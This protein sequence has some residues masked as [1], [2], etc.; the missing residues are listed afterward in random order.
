MKKML[1]GLMLM[2]VSAVVSAATISISEFPKTDSYQVATISKVT[3]TDTFR[4]YNLST[5][6]ATGNLSG[7]IEVWWDL[8]SD[9]DANF[10]IAMNASASGGL[11]SSWGVSVLNSA[12]EQLFS[13]GLGQVGN[14]DIKAGETLKAL[15]SGNFS[16]VMRF[17]SWGDKD[18]SCKFKCSDPHPEPGLSA[19]NASISLSDIT[20]VEVPPVSEVPLPA[21]VWL[22]GSALLGG[23]AV[24]RKR[25]A[26]KSASVC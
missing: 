13:G 24:R 14:I 20:K 16:D 25:K 26:S 7:P 18:K 8:S 10:N 22:F 15:I 9:V 21:A 11:N 5:N 17:F 1:F 23:F 4:E 6:A 19:F 3:F 12:N 2:W